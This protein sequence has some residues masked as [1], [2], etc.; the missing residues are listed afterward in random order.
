MKNSLLFTIGFFCLLSFSSCREDMDAS[1]LQVYDGPINTAI[2]INLVQSDSAIV[3]SQIKAAKQLEYENGNLEF[4]EGIDIQ[5]FDEEGNVTTTMK[6]NK[7]YYLREENLYKGVGDV[8]VENMVKDQS[9][10]A[11]EM[12]WNPNKKQIYTEKFVTVRD[13][14]TLFNGTGME[15]DESFTNYTLKNIRDSRT[16]LPGEGM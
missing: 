4:P 12:F 5:F 11:E 14:Q 6:A 15:A 7:G 1:A 10:K 3:R 2:N 16:L 8:Q 9:L 13:G